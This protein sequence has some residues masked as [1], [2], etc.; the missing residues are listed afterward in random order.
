MLRDYLSVFRVLG[1]FIL[2]AV[3]VGVIVRTQLPDMQSK[4]ANLAGFLGIV[5]LAVPTIRLNEQAR[6][7]Y[8]ANLLIEAGKAAGDEDGDL[9]KIRRI[10]ENRRGA[11][12]PLVQR[13]L[14]LG[15]ALMFLSA[16]LRVF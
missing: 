3:L 6:Q 14:Y 1:I 2:I 4:L 9:K 5:L 15:Y 13:A 8:R 16:L 11:W 10:L 7:V 12:S